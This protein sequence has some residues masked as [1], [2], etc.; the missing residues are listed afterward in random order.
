MP[1]PPQPLD[2]HLPGRTLPRKPLNRPPLPQQLLHPQ[3]WTHAAPDSQPQ[4]WTH[5]PH[6]PVS[7]GWHVSGQSAHVPQ[8]P[9][10]RQLLGPQPLV[11]QHPLRPADS[12]T[13]S[14]RNRVRFIVKVPFRVDVIRRDWVLNIWVKTGLLSIQ[15]GRTFRRVQKI[16]RT[17]LSHR[18][19]TTDPTKTTAPERL[20]IVLK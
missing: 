16:G 13:A 20:L 19:I 18:I 8:L 3:F 6:P 7:Q 1:D 4:F 10:I 5:E 17:S 12:T 15:I 9:S 11:P 2:A 14:I